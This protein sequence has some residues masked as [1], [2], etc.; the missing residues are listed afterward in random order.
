ML[1]A[2]PLETDF[3]ELHNQ[4][5]VMGKADV[6]PQL[7]DES[8]TAVEKKRFAADFMVRRLTGLEIGGK[9]HTKNMYRLEWRSGGVEHYDQPLTTADDRQR[10]VVGLVQKKVSEVLTGLGKRRGNRFGRSFQMGMLA[11]FESFLQTTKVKTH[12]EDESAFDQTYQTDDQFEKEGVDSRSIQ[13]IAES[14]RAQFREPLP[15]PK[16]DSVADALGDSMRRGEKVL[17]FVRRIASV[18][19][20]S[21]KTSRYY[22]EWLL[23]HLLDGTKRPLARRIRKLYD[24][25]LD[26][27]RRSAPSN[28]HQPA[29]PQRRRMKRKGGDPPN[30]DPDD[31]GGRDDFFTWFFRGKGPPGV[32]SGAAFRKNRFGSEGSVLSTFFEDNHVAWLLGYPNNVLGALVKALGIPLLELRE[33]LR[34]RAFAA[35]VSRSKQKKFPRLRVHRAY[36]EAMLGLLAEL[37]DD[38]GERARTVLREWFPTVRKVRT[39]KP[40]DAFPW[41]DVPVRTRTFFTE[42]MRRPALQRELWPEPTR[43]DVTDFR[44]AFRERER[45]REMLAAAIA[46]GHPFIDLWLLAIRRLGT[47]KLGA[48]ERGG[49]VAPNLAKAFLD[50]LD[51]QDPEAGLNSRRELAEIG[52]HFHLILDV[53]FP[54]TRDKALPELARYFQAT[55]GRQTPVGGM[56]GGVNGTLVRQFRMPG[57]P[58]VLVTTDVLQEGEDLH[59]FAAKVMH[60]GISWT[61]SAMEQRTGRVDRIGSLAHRRLAG[62]P[63]A[64]DSDLLQVYFPYLEETVE[65]VQVREIFRRMNRFVEL[66]HEGFGVQELADSKLDLG[67]AILHHTRDL[68]PSREPLHSSFDIAGEWLQRGSVQPPAVSGAKAADLLTHFERMMK[69]LESHVAIEWLDSP[70]EGTRLGTV[71]LHQAHLVPAGGDLT[72]DRSQPFAAQLHSTTGGELL[73]LRFMSPIGSVPLDDEAV[74]QKLLSIHSRLPTTKLCSTEDRNLRSFNLETAVDILFGTD[75]T[76][77]EELVSSLRRATHGADTLERMVLDR[78][79]PMRAFEADLRREIDRG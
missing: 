43:A 79:N 60:Y 48:E 74:L 47:L 77:V 58:Y 63:K 53:N 49:E 36:Q 73:L 66:L 21:E 30:I 19:E 41:P 17:V 45:R 38:V 15:H 44:E 72:E 24:Q 27:C 7:V 5:D 76:Q 40:P 9:R 78:D 26:E 68:E 64:E 62:Q 33:V 54:D 39:K 13:A 29:E 4:M 46:L 6:A 14:Y 1:S 18:S 42:L 75:T 28:V 20:L 70:Q 35:F 69:A 71:W 52:R 25:Y 65:L 32:L 16:M 55:L 51:S 67:T 56:W 10:L 50:L 8:L 31:E 23:D 61:P 22:D 59:T 34:E 11:S 57:Y 12:E 37:D 2:T 3:R